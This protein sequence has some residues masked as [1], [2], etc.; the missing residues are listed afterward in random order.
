MIGFDQTDFNLGNIKYGDTKVVTVNITNT[1][2]ET[3]ELTPMN[4]SCSCTTGSLKQSKLAPNERT[5]FNISLNSTKA[6]KGTNQVKSIQLNY[7][8]GGSTYNQVFRLKANVV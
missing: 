3:V 4:S 8:I 5:Q 6:G 2:T 7:K 1:S